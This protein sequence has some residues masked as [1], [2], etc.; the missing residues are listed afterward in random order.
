MHEALDEVGE[1]REVYGE[2]EEPH[3]GPHGMEAAAFDGGSHGAQKAAGPIAKRAVG[4]TG[5]GDK[6]ADHFPA[7]IIYGVS[8]L[9]GH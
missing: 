4:A 9:I 8:R 2:V 3:D 1:V 5:V 6:T 7:L